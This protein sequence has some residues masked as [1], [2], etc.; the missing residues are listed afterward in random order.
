[1]MRLG[2]APLDAVQD[3]VAM[4]AEYYPEYA[5]NIFAVNSSGGHA[6]VAHPP[7][8]APTPYLVTRTSG[9]AEP[10]IERYEATVLPDGFRRRKYRLI[11][12]DDE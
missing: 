10:V 1:M 12:I 9:G 2:L 6:S 5:G 8:A 3:A 11:A 4:I 7:T